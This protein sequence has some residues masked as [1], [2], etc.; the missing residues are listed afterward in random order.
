M[1]EHYDQAM[2]FRVTAESHP[3]STHLSFLTT[4]DN[5]AVTQIWRNERQ[6]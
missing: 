5:A 3:L 4:C 6:E 1:S 2:L